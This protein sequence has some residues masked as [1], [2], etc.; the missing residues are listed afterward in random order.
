MWESNIRKNDH[1]LINDEVMVSKWLSM[2][3]KKM[4]VNL[5]KIVQI[6]QCRNE[7]M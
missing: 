6:I 1:L 2:V 7:K 4:V 3:S 5:I